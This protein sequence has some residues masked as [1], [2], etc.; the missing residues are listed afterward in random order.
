M[1]TN[2][3]DVRFQGFEKSPANLII[4]RAPDNF[5]HFLT[6]SHIVR[7]PAGVFI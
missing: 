1:V 6:W 3:T 5:S 2:K 4:A 7:A